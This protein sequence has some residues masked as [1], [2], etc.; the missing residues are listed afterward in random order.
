MICRLLCELIAMRA[1]SAAILD[2]TAPTTIEQL[3]SPIGIPEEQF[4]EVQN[5]Q[6]AS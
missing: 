2:S 4:D 1:R 6:H 3:C 5:A